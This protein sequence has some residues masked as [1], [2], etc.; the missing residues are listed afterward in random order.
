MDKHPLDRPIAD[1]ISTQVIQERL[2]RING[3]GKFPATQSD[4]TLRDFYSRP[5]VVVLDAVPADRE[6]VTDGFQGET[7]RFVSER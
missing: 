2:E 5:R 6:P 1:D 4:F 3:R 7:P